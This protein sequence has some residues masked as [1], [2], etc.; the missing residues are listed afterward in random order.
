DAPLNV[1]G[2]TGKESMADIVSSPAIFAAKVV[3]VGREGRGSIS[4]AVGPVQ[5]VHRKEG[6]GLVQAVGPAHYELMLVEYAAGFVL[7]D[8]T[9]RL[10][11]PLSREDARA[12][13]A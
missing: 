1:H 10:D 7:I 8:V 3:L 5:R 13:T 2:A 6:K 4:I 11:R 12:W 9:S